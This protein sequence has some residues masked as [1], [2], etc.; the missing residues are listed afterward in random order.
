MS[1]LNFKSIIFGKTE[2]YS[3]RQTVV[4]K[5]V[6]VMISSQSLLNITFDSD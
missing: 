4:E 1:S 6:S 2:E 5:L 3:I